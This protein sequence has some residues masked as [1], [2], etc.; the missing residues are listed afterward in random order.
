MEF[1]N[2]PRLYIMIV[3]LSLIAVSSLIYYYTRYG[4][5]DSSGSELQMILLAIPLG[6]FGAIA[7]MLYKADIQI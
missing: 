6:I 1:N 4:V 2:E 7:Y 5:K 3:V